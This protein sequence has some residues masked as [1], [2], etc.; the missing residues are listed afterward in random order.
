V[1]KQKHP[2][3]PSYEYS[4]ES[5]AIRMLQPRRGISKYCETGVVHLINTLWI[6]LQNNSWIYFALHTDNMTILC[7][8]EEPVDIPIKG[9][10]K[11]SSSPGCKG[12]SISAMLQAS[13][14]VTCNL[15]L[16]DGNLLPQVPS[17]M[18]VVNSWE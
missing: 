11:L 1:C 2:L 7:R 12:Y 4:Q 9:M 16:K 17:N 3:F 15:T 6:H 5:W 8:D 14:I 13:S 10:G 18:I